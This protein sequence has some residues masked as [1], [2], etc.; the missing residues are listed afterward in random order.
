MLNHASV[1]FRR[2]SEFD[3]PAH[4]AILVGILSGKPRCGEKEY[5]MDVAITDLVVGLENDFADFYTRVEALSRFSE[6]KPIFQWMEKQS[7]LHARQVERISRDYSVPGG[8]RLATINDIQ[9]RITGILYNEIIREPN[10]TVVWGKLADAEE[11]VALLYRRIAE[12]F[13]SLSPDNAPLAAEF[14]RLAGDEMEHRDA[15][16]QERDKY[17]Q[18]RARS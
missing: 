16:L 3:L 18:Q 8:F 13:R 6:S 12:Y 2:A 9:A 1:A 7:R 5:R 11:T 17:R 14:D 15:I 4:R 10:I